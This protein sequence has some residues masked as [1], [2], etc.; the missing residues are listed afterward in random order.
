MVTECL[1]ATANGFG[2]VCAVPVKSSMRVMTT[3][4][5]TQPVDRNQFYHVQTPQAFPLL[6]L[7]EF[8]NTLHSKEFTDDATLWEA[9]GGKVLLVTGNYDNIKLT[10]PEDMA[11]AE[12]LL[13]GS[14]GQ[15]KHT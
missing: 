12:I 5:S 13:Q 1:K 15:L 4:G 10:T 3:D 14:W 6:P 11:V 2:A 8:Y 9:G 7:L